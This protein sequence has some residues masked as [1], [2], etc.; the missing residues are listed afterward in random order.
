MIDEDLYIKIHNL[1][2][3]NKEIL[4]KSKKCGCFHCKKIFETNK[5]IQWIE[6]EEG[7]TA[8]CPY[9]C[10]DSVIPEKSKLQYI[11]SEELLEEMRKKWFENEEGETMK[12]RIDDYTEFELNIKR[13]NRYKK[14]WDDKWCA[15][16]LKIENTYFKYNIKDREILVEDEISDLIVKF[17]DLLNGK[18]TKQEEIDF[19]EP[20]LEFILY[21]SKTNSEHSVMDL[22]IHL[23]Q[24]YMLSED[25]YSMCLDAKEIRAIMEYLNKVIP[26][27]QIENNTVEDEEN[28][29]YCV[30]SVKY[31]DYN[32]E[33]EY[34]YLFDKRDK[35]LNIGE[36]VLVDRAGYKVVANVMDIKYYSENDINNMPYPLEKM[37]KVIEVLN[38][39][40][41][42]NRYIRG[43]NGKYKCPCCENYTLDEI[44]AFEI[45][46]ECSW[47]DDP[48]QWEKEELEGGAN[49]LCLK[50]AKEQYKKTKK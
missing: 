23:Y 7:S 6:D 1:S 32:G 50:E 43:E 49:K 2:Y 12:L 31:V 42:Y 24:T 18:I 15:V 19:I 17:N 9:C 40:K 34:A 14:Q 30:V 41:L 26:T 22:K 27:I 13:T 5:I 4:K 10:I 36:F 3:E 8:V 48:I 44:E 16:S 38:D 45:C 37:K 28:Q 47:E 11:L 39:E 25:F 29:D 20:D 33:K 46:S 35:E 21:P